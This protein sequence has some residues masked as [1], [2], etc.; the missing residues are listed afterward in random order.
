MRIWN[1]VLLYLMWSLWQEC[2]CIKIENLEIKGTYMI[3]LFLDCCLSGP[4]LGAGRFI[5]EFLESLSSCA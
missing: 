4:V 5:S 2:N 3:E 1:L